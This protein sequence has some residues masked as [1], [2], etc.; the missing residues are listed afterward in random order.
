MQNFLTFFYPFGGG[1]ERHTAPKKYLKKK[2]NIRSPS[3]AE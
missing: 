2:N 1:A 3:D